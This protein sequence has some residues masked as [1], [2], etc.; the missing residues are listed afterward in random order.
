[1]I[2]ATAPA[3]INLTLR[4]GAV[5]DDGYHPLD[6]I[7]VFADR[8]DA[9]TLAPS[10]EF[11]LSLEG[12][13]A[14]G[15]PTGEGNLVI[16]AVRSLAMAAGREAEGAITL[17]KN[18][19]AGAGL[20]G[21]SAD[22]AAAL[23]AYNQFW[24]LDWPLDMLAGIGAQIGSD[25]PACLWSQPL[26]MTGRGERIRLIDDWPS[27]H[28]IL[29][30]PRKALATGSVFKQFDALPTG[31][32]KAYIG[33]ADTGRTAVMSA[34]SVA[35]NDLTPAALAVEPVIGEVLDLLTRTE[36]AELVRMSGSGASCVA[37]YPSELARDA[38]A[39][40]VQAAQ[41]D[42]LVLP[43]QLAGSSASI[44]R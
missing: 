36:A 9:L 39:R 33:S 26:R 37:L 3:K 11:S 34:L 29:V 15:I 28:A 7:V 44:A 22:A 17:T 21:G 19:P 1:M 35:T 32:G 41:P 14:T 12:P 24:E 42:W 40:I 2:R 27:F 13:E 4:V 6:S 5:Q 10:A 18:I 8:G 20:G 16:R 43:V 38:A 31:T 30:Y 25:I 23:R